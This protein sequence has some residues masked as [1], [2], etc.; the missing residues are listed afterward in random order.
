MARRVEALRA[1]L[2]ELGYV[3][4][5]NLVI[6]FRWA[7]GYYERLPDLAADRGN[8]RPLPRGSPG[9]GLARTGFSDYGQ[10][11]RYAS[12]STSQRRMDRSA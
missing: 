1:G 4:G 9:C 2:G 7:E 6:E 3:E 11:I 8:P 5:K 12:A 10:S